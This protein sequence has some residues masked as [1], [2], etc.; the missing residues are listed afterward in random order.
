MLN[1]Y[2]EFF[3]IS[4]KKLKRE[5]LSTHGHLD[6]VPGHPFVEQL[7]H[8]TWRSDQSARVK[9]DYLFRL[10]SH[11]PYCQGRLVNS[12]ARSGN[13]TPVYGKVLSEGA[14]MES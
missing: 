2:A 6:P 12:D 7:S 5:P 8:V 14:L 4:E 11:H 10:T 3:P 1:I 13:I 9:I